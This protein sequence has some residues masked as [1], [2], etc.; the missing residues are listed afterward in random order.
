MCKR[1]E[2]DSEY[3]QKQ[4]VVFQRSKSEV[5]EFG[6]PYSVK[7]KCPKKCEMWPNGEKGEK[8]HEF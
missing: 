3:K 2:I 5:V 6:C 4:G 7:V 8:V 1:Q